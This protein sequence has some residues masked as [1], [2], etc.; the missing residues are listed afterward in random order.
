MGP[1][2]VFL[3]RVKT[4]RAVWTCGEVIG[5]HGLASGNTTDLKG[6]TGGD[7]GLSE[8]DRYLEG[9]RPGRPCTR[10]QVIKV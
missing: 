8:S 9:V 1:T 10:A 6:R 2:F 5:S 7:T 3:S 4:G